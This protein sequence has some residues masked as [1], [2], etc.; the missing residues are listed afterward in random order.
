MR[1]RRDTDRGCDKKSST[2]RAGPISAAKK[3]HSH[4]VQTGVDVVVGELA[5]SAVPN[6]AGNVYSFERSSSPQL[7]NMG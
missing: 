5:D 2:C 4:V 6:S 1:E 3:D 7:F